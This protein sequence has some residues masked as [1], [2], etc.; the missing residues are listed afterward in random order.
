MWIR[1]SF[2]ALLV[3]QMS[4]ALEELNKG[5]ILE[6]ITLLKETIRADPANGTAYFYLCTY[7]LYIVYCL[8]LLQQA[9][10]DAF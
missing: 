6:G 5:H 4:S 3:G 8:H 10:A 2:I 9:F 1:L 7:K